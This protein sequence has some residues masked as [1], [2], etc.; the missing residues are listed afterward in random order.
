MFRWFSNCKKAMINDTDLADLGVWP[1]RSR[2]N[3]MR[4]M[5]QSLLHE[6]FVKENPYFSKIITVPE[7][8][9]NKGMLHI[10]LTFRELLFC[11]WEWNIG[12][13]CSYLREKSNRR[14][15]TAKLSMWIRPSVYCY[16]KNL[17]D[18]LGPQRTKF[19]SSI[20]RFGHHD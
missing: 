17:P 13:N 2:D 11:L 10:V 18:L 12:G 8:L 7:N 3:F 15:F 1:R 20:T 16:P 4:S 5:T 6:V 14:H 9:S 19:S